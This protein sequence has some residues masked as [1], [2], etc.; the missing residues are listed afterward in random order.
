MSRPS[1]S[2]ATS[3]AFDFALFAEVLRLPIG[4]AQAENEQLFDRLSSIVPLEV[5]RFPSGREHNGWIVPHDWRVRRAE[6]RKDGQLLF[7]GTVH[8]LAVAGSSTGF[9]GVVSKRE[10]DEHV[11]TNRDFP[12]AYAFHSVYNYR[13]WQRHWGFCVPHAVYESWSEGEY[14]IDLEVDF[15]VGEMLVGF[16]HHAGESTDTIVF[17]AHTCHPVQANDDMAGVMVVLELLR[18]LS[19]RKTKYSYLGVLAPEHLGTVFYLADLDPRERE[20]LKLCTFVEM[21]GT[22]GQLALQESFTG[23]SIIDRMAAHLLRQSDPDVRVGAFRTIVG[24]DETVWEA[25][26]IEIPTISISRWP[27]PEYHTSADSL[28]IMSPARLTEALD[29]LKSL[30]TMLEEDCTIER[31]FS[32]LIAL[33]NP[34]YSLYVERPDPVLGKDLSPLDLRLGLMQDYLPRFFDGDTTVFEIA[35]RFGIPFDVLRAYIGRFEEKGLVR[36]H[37]V[38]HLDRYARS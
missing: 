37:D 7:D 14:E 2:T 29:V 25:P 1:K 33:S 28:E 8:P 5:L 34:K 21:V 36:L 27:Y 32:G 22:Q 6:I 9:K 4:V 35:E 10:L 13:P 18:W 20:R 17:N 23:T 26:G 12:D 31:Q 19:G 15:V 3:A 30:V 16:H 11:F 24:N 38:R